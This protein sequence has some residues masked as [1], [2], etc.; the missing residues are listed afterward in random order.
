MTHM[1]YIHQTSCISPQQTFYNTAIDDLETPVNN[2]LHAVEPAYNDMP[3]NS[4]RRMGKTARIGIGAAMPLIK[5]VEGFNGIIIGT[6]NGG[7]EDSV[8]FLKEI[9]EYNEGLLTPGHFVQSTANALASQLSLA[10]LNRGYNI[11]HVHR[12][13]AFEMAA[14]DT[15]MLLRENARNCYLLGGVDEI[16]SYNYKLEC[17]DGWYKKEDIS[18]GGFYS[19]NTTGTVAGE[20]AVMLLV[21]NDKYNAV[22]KVVNISTLHTIVAMKM[23]QHLQQFLEQHI[24]TNIDLLL[25]GE[26]GDSRL[27][28]YYAN[29]E[30]LLKNDIAVA[31]FKHMCGEYPTSSAFA[32]WLACK[33]ISGVPLPAHMLK[34]GDS[35]TTYSNILIYNCH[36]GV[37]HSFML[38]SKTE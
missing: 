7:M 10:S 6:G 37:Q 2:R 24:N 31:R 25:S 17:L 15:A 28:A 19:S 26:N 4:L 35:K 30:N 36:K 34:K 22:A 18:S 38:V 12:G 9:I 27:L 29:A 16:S 3:K 14:I 11:T 23:Q 5:Q 13:L 1:F 20:G 32:L 8:I 33:L 21:N